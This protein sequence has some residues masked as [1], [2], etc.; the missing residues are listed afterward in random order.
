MTSKPDVTSIPHSVIL[1][2]ADEREVFSFQVAAENLPSFSLD[3]SLYPTFGSKLIGKAVMLPSTFDQ[4]K[5]HQSFV[6]PLLD[7]NLKTIGEVSTFPSSSSR[8]VALNLERNEKAD[9]SP[10]SLSFSQVAFELSVVRPFIGVQLEIG[11]RV[12]TYWKSTTVPTFSG[13]SQ[14]HGRQFQPHRPLSVATSSPLLTGSLAPPPPPLLHGANTENGL[15]TS[16]SLS[17]EYVNII[18]Q[19]TKDLVPM[20]YSEWALPIAGFQLGVCDVTA[21]QFEALAASLEKRLED[22]R[23][24]LDESSSAADWFRT[25]EGSMSSLETVLSVSPVA[26]RRSFLLSLLS[27][28]PFVDLRN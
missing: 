9:I 23:G 26:S 22:Q 11:G 3:F 12:E 25:I 21:K 27:L 4:I 18:V 10:L 5:S 24:M 28:S 14:D 2:L 13:L 20:V 6:A 15:V 19:V 7:H 17:G 16:T 8:S 1:P